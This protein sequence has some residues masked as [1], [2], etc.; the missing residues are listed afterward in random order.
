MSHLSEDQIEWVLSQAVGTGEAVGAMSHLF[1]C[2]PC[3]VCAEGVLTRR[4]RAKGAGA[5][6]LRRYLDLQQENVVEL[7]LADAQWSEMR[8]LGT[9]VQKEKVATTS[10]CKTGAFVRLLLSELKATG[11]WEEAERLATLIVAAVNVMDS[12]QYPDILKNDMKGEA[13]TELANSRRRAAEWKRA[14]ESLHLAGAFLSQGSGSRWL[15]GRRLS[16][17]A[18]LETDRGKLEKALTDLE[19]AKAVYEQLQAPRFVART[20]LQG[21]NALSE[22]DPKRGLL[23]LDEADPQFPSGDPLL[24]NA[25]L[26]RIDCLIWTGQ[27]REAIGYLTDCERPKGR[28]QIRY[29][30][31]GARLLHALGYRKESERIFQDVVT[32]DLESSHYKDALLDLLYILKIHVAE[33]ETAKALAVCRRALSEALLV[34]FS[35]EQL[36]EVWHQVLDAIEKKSFLP[37]RVPSLRHYMSLH[38]RHPATHLPNVN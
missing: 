10:I 29:R 9:K 14:S 16:V 21:A 6:L 4:S 13:M 11:A 24:L 5:E 7:L 30:F 37:E 8:G 19:A 33:G 32:E 15:E 34:D 25:R 18:S 17:S 36:R 1:E 23:F 38:W 31:I 28:M 27:T 3:L 20:L 2:L 12:D 35:H 22:L 26:C